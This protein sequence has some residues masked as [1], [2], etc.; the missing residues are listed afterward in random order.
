MTLSYM[1][2]FTIPKSQQVH[3]CNQSDV[4]SQN[5]ILFEEQLLAF[6]SSEADHK[7]QSASYGT[8]LN[9]LEYSY[10]TLKH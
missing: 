5:I 7:E 10:L 4:H 3:G 8:G 9:W 1:H 6:P 2:D